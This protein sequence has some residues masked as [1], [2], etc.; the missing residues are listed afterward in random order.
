MTLIFLETE[1]FQLAAT[2]SSEGVSG[3]IDGTPYLGEQFAAL[4]FAAQDSFE[5][6]L[7]AAADP[8]DLASV[9]EAAKLREELR[10]FVQQVKAV[11][12]V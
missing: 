8:Q 1:E 9:I 7:M 11:I 2:C 5:V 6:S 12:T 4:L 3:H 10:N